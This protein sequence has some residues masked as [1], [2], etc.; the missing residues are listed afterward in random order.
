MTI[1]ANKLF[2]TAKE[3]NVGAMVFF[4]K[5]QGGW[6]ETQRTEITGKDGGDVK[7]QVNALSNAE[8]MEIA[9]LTIDDET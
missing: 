1:I 6:K 2:E 3:G 9:R 8:L 4:L 5:T 7:M